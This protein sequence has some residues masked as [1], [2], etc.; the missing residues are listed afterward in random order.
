M[1]TTRGA[2]RPAPRNHNSAPIS[3]GAAA[4]DGSRLSPGTPS[5]RIPR[6][7]AQVIR[8]GSRPRVVGADSES[9]A[10]MSEEN[11][12]VT[13]SNDTTLTSQPGI[14]DGSGR[15]AKRR[16]R[17]RRKGKG[18]AESGGAPADGVVATAEAP[19]SAS[20]ANSDADHAR[21]PRRSPSEDR[22]SAVDPEDTKH[23][24]SESSFAELGLRNSVLKGVAEMGFQ[25]PTLIQS[26]LIPPVLEGHDVLGQART[27]SGKTAAFGLPL[28]HLAQRE[29]PFQSIVLVP[30]RE[31]AIQIAG[32]LSNFGKHT[33]IRVAAVF[34]G[35]AVR[36]QQDELGEGPEIIVATP[37]RLMD[38]AER[39]DLHFRNVRFIVLDE[40][41][42]MLDIG[43]RDDIRRILGQVRTAHQTIFVSATISD[44]IENLASHYLTDPVRIASL[45]GALTVEL[46]QQYYLSVERWDKKRLLVHLLTHEDPDLTL[47]FCSTKRMVDDLTKHL[48]EKNIDARAIHGDLPQRKRNSV[49]AR[50]RSGKLGVVVASDVAA[51]GLDVEGISHVVNYDIPVDPEIYVH[52]I[53]RTARAGRRGVAWSFVTSEEGKLL[54]AVEKF[55]NIE[56]P[57]LEYPDFTPGPTPRG[58]R[59]RK[60]QQA[61]LASPATTVASRAAAP[62]PPAPTVKPDARR[63]PGGI[64]PSKLPPKMLGG[65]VQTSRSMRQSAPVPTEEDSGN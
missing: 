40:V 64:I 46:V 7:A 23:L 17:R 8:P 49:M 47:V 2:K 31:L 37:G 6:A 32:E 9:V 1:E 52:R 5:W 35:E 41:D 62:K 43:F 36:K 15:P 14:T 57:K 53:G 54:T 26:E 24:F 56:V 12:P 3:K 61:Q 10:R 42:R 18:D 45:S 60:A 44:E 59:D 29:V 51:R 11:Q 19:A 39:G 22:R 33:P 25:S 65:R 28:F 27:G 30:T 13:S 63:F 4:P 50:F 21:K 20:P 16:R 55:A 34:G 38:F 58:V 48:N